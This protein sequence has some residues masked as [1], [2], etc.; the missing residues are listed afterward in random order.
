NIH[1]IISHAPSRKALFKNAADL[2]PVQFPDTTCRSNRFFFRVNDKAG[3]AII[4]HFGNRTGAKSDHG[5]AARHRFDHHQTKWLRPID[6]E[7]KCSSPVQKTLL[8][9]IITSPTSWIF[10][11]S[12]SGSRCSLKYSDGREALWQLCAAAFPSFVQFEWRYGHPFHASAG[13][14]RLSIGQDGRRASARSLAFHDRRCRAI[15]RRQGE[16]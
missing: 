6:R 2:A 11:P 13:R 15:L 14:E 9:T 8:T 4:D 10:F 16:I 12:M 7:K 1:I 5:C 3:H